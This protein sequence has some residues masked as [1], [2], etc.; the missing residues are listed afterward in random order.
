MKRIEALVIGGLMLMTAGCAASSAPE[1]VG[2]DV[3]GAWSG[4]WE[5]VPRSAGSGTISMTLKQDGAWVSGPIEVVGPTLH[6]PTRLEGRVIGE[7]VQIIGPIG[8][9]WLT[10]NGDEMTGEINGFLPVKLAA[11]RQR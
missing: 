8:D 6:R 3:A 10:V 9:G 1:R 4:T 7:R 5:F 11:R 2:I